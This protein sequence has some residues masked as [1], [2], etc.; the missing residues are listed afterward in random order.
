MPA[1]SAIAPGVVPMFQMWIAENEGDIS[2]L[3]AR[4]MTWGEYNTRRR[5]RAA[6]L[7]QQ[8]TAELQRVG[9]LQ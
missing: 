4:R 8:M 2:A 9:Q 5:D 6:K 7:Q 3:K 1:Y